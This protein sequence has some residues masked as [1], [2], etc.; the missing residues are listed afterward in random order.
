MVCKSV[1]VGV[2]TTVLGVTPAIAAEGQARL[3]AASGRVLVNQGH[4]YHQAS[5]GKLLNTG[6]SIF[7][8]DES[9]ATITYVADNCEVA[10]NTP[11]VHMVGAL[12][13]CQAKA[14]QVEP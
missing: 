11:R 3:T 5:A 7:I 10:V 1:F 14:V 8:G 9:I 13:P 12:S 4:G 2:L 6:D